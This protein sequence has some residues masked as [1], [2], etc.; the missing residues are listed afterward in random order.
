MAGGLQVRSPAVPVRFAARCSIPC[1]AAA[2]QEPCP[3]PWCTVGAPA[4]DAEPASLPW[5]PQPGFG[6]NNF[7]NQRSGGR[8][9]GKK[10]MRLES[11]GIDGNRL[12]LRGVDV[13]R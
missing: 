1:I 12:V 5:S 3:P 4:V 8:D 7:G 13:S 6:M 11:T 10:E 2:G 9:E